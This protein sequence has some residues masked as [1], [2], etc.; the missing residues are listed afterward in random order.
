MGRIKPSF[1]KDIGKK[2]LESYKFE[3]DFYKVKRKIAELG[4]FESKS[5]RNK[6]AGYIVRNLKVKGG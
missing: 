1:I 5:V 3:K 6:V 4:I 2:L